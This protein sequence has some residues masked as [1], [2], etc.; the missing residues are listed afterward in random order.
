[1]VAPLRSRTAQ[2]TTGGVDQR[3]LDQAAPSVAPWWSGLRHSRQGAL[4]LDSAGRVLLASLAAGELLPGCLP[5][6]PMAEVLALAEPDGAGTGGAAAFAATPFARA[7]RHDTLQRA[8]VRVLT[9]AGPVTFDVCAVPL[10]GPGG[11]EAVL[12]FLDPL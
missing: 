10:R 4:V 8:L 1:M 12:A 11:V 9:P 2:R 7:L 6:R 3:E 5:G